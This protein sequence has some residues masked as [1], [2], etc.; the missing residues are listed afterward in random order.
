MRS[1]S[2]TQR[3]TF[4]RVLSFARS[5]EKEQRMRKNI[6]LHTIKWIGYT[7]T[8]QRGRGVVSYVC[9]VEGAIVLLCYILN[10]LL[11]TLPVYIST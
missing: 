6:T 10:Y 5:L 7:L 1:D 4:K 3:D 2:A 9:T 11:Y 8:N